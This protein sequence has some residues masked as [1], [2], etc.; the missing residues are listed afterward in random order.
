MNNIMTRTSEKSF[1]DSF[2]TDSEYGKQIFRINPFIT[3][4]EGEFPVKVLQVMHVSNKTVIIEM[5]IVESVNDPGE[6]DGEE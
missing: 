2:D 4:S 6:K 5:E 1:F 3:I